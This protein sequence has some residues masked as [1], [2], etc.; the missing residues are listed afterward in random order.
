MHDLK[1]RFSVWSVG[2]LALLI[3][4]EAG[5]SAQSNDRLG[6]TW[7]GP[8]SSL[9]MSVL[10]NRKPAVSTTKPRVSVLTFQPSA[11]SGVARSL[12][13]A[14]GRTAEEKT[15]L[16]E[17]F[18]QIKAAYEA[19]V[20]KAGKSNN[21]AAAMTFFVTAN[22]AA[23]HQIE[24]PGDEVSENIF[25]SLEDSMSSLP[26]FAQ[27]SNAE[28]QQMHDWLVAMAGFVMAGSMEAKKTNDKETLNNFS[29][30][31]GYSLRLVLGVDPSKLTINGNSLAVAESGPSLPTS[32]ASENKIVGVWSKSA[33][34]PTG[35]AGTIDGT[36]KLATNAGYYKGQYQF[37]ADGT[38]TF[39]GES[40]GGYLR[41]NEFWTTEERGSF[42]VNG[43]ELKV[44]PATSKK[45]L[46]NREGVIQRT[47]NNPIERVTYKWRLHYF[48]GLNET[49]LVLQAARE[50]LRDGG[51]SGN[52]SFPSSFLYSST[53]NMEWRF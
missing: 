49:H 28:R 37:N 45:T 40:W 4:F 35:L 46:R 8:N 16:I 52:S 11:D 6:E 3:C 7:K 47:M 10:K 50:N 53:R 2:I 41:S 20:K 21:L 13:D 33:S 27:M 32:G 12:A 9:I 36:Q 1:L 29:E 24:I 43:D 5:V 22:V 42:A 39:K 18:A 34:S 30:L 19:E 48:E 44:S 14:L 51:F 38:Y 25:K 23:F 31:A 26:A 15:A 17:A